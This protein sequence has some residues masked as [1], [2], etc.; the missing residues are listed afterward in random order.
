MAVEKNEGGGAGTEGDHLARAELEMKKAREMG[1]E[2]EHIACREGDDNDG[3]GTDGSFVMVMNGGDSD[4]RSDSSEKDLE[5]DVRGG[6]GGAGDLL[7]ADSGST[8]VDGGSAEESKGD[9]GVERQGNEREEERKLGD[10]FSAENEGKD[11]HVV[12]GEDDAHDGEV[13]QKILSMPVELEE[14]IDESTKTDHAQKLEEHEEEMVVVDAKKDQV[15]EGFVAV[16]DS[17]EEKNAVI[18]ELNNKDEVV[19][20]EVFKTEKSDQVGEELLMVEDSKNEKDIIIEG[21][22]VVDEAIDPIVVEDLKNKEQNQVEEEVVIVEDSKNEMEAVIEYLNKLD[23]VI[24][25]TEE[26][27]SEGTEVSYAKNEVDS[28]N[29][30]LTVGASSAQSSSSGF[31]DRNIK[32]ELL[33]G[34][35]DAVES[36]VTKLMN[37]EAESVPEIEELKEGSEQKTGDVESSI[38]EK[39]EADSASEIE[40]RRDANNEVAVEINSSELAKEEISSVHEIEDSKD[41]NH[42]ECEDVDSLLTDAANEG[43]DSNSEVDESRNT[44]DEG[45]KDVESSKEKISSVFDIEDRR[46]DNREECEDVESSVRDAATKG[47]DSNLEV[48]ERKNT[49]IEV[50]KDVESEIAD[51]MDN[52]VYSASEVIDRKI[53]NDDLSNCID[54]ENEKNSVTQVDENLQVKATLAVSD[55]ESGEL[56]TS[57]ELLKQHNVNASLPK[58]EIEEK[59][60][61]S[62]VELIDE[63]VMK[64]SR[65]APIVEEYQAAE[66]SSIGQSTEPVKEFISS[67][68]QAEVEYDATLSTSSAPEAEEDKNAK[69]LFIASNPEHKEDVSLA[70][71]VE[72]KQD[73]DASF[74]DSN[75]EPIRL[76][77]S[78]S[79]VGEL[80]DADAP[81][82]DSIPE[83]VKEDVGL[84]SKSEENQNAEAL[85]TE[86][87]NEKREL[88]SATELVEVVSK[89]VKAKE[90]MEDRRKDLN[91]AEQSVES[92]RIEIV[93]E[94][95]DLKSDT[96]LTEHKKIHLEKSLGEIEEQQMELKS[97]EKMDALNN[98]QQQG[99]E[100]SSAPDGDLEK[101]EMAAKKYR[102]IK[103]PRFTQRVINDEHQAKITDAHAQ[104]DEH[105]RRRDSLK[106]ELDN[107]RKVLSDCFHKRDSTN[108]EEKKAKALVNAKRLEMDSIQTVISKGK[109]AASF[110]DIISRIHTLEYKMQH[111]TIS[112]KDEKKYLHELNQLKNERELH[113]FNKC[114]QLEIDDALKQKET[115]ESSFKILKK[116]FDTLRN[117]HLKADEYLKSVSKSYIDQ[118]NK[119]KEHEQ[120][121]KTAND[122]RQNAY[123]NLHG[124]KSDKME[125]YWKYMDDRQVA[126]KYAS[127]KDKEA[128]E[129]HC[130]EQ[131]ERIMRLW[132]E[133][134]DF[135][136][137]YVESN[138]NNTL[139][140][141][142][143][144]DG[145]TPGPNDPKLVIPQQNFP[146]LTT[147]SSPATVSVHHEQSLHSHKVTKPA[148]PTN[149]MVRSKLPSE[150]TSND[151]ADIVAPLREEFVELEVEKKLTIEEEEQAR[152]AEEQARKAEELAR[153]EEELRKV[154]EE[155]EF[156]EKLRMEQKAKAKDAEE[157]KRRKA[158]KAQAKAE[159]KAQKQTELRELRLKKEKKKEGTSE[160]D[161]IV[162]GDRA[163]VTETSSQEAS[164]EQEN[165]NT[166]SS[167]RSRRKSSAAL[168]KYSNKVQPVPLPLRNRGKRKMSAWIWTFCVAVALIGLFFA[169]NYI[170]FSFSW[171]KFGF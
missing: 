95:R 154:R 6:G 35:S 66:V 23:E 158:E 51:H 81:S 133:D 4:A 9:N 71:M 10:S 18:E 14:F 151:V 27:V 157:R 76:L 22:Y 145:R 93:H 34:I 44:N 168:N 90:G 30:G 150:S 24:M 160:K 113:P 91:A 57:V 101:A 53:A 114:S 31:V 136:K 5:M 28:D 69:M 85:V 137:Q 118:F 50:I 73:L 32:L 38:T 171:L 17:K 97:E 63:L 124:L 83:P 102:L 116:E 138:L 152:L 68:S 19:D 26:Q 82:I 128:L 8:F 7:V 65:S 109:T 122:F 144:L 64:D 33:I 47:V 100:A 134:D 126:K 163:S 77:A 40:E 48:E 15:E 115:A 79:E 12:G 107:M 105:T 132:N 88:K 155:L 41:E 94:T 103:I 111:E 142:G 59:E 92:S 131:V 29:E 110:L 162:E 161:G 141:F 3:S 119:V 108:E 148:L 125:H 52:E 120:K 169:G 45:I 130:T 129:R 99:N 139:R 43:V 46:D 60:N 127:S 37:N 149:L 140:K 74:I 75:T 143:T 87:E 49:N 54:W 36:A 96:E 70:P 159:Y 104:V 146:P 16:E 165:N 112:L 61:D 11:D 55:G 42:E 153:K 164:Q 156:K 98:Q 147:R 86:G 39:K 78:T 106:A 21:L 67:T 167:K 123:K 89:P 72:E 13:A 117:A 84:A 62:S 2:I 135:R 170:S 25:G 166:T 20:I 56:V 80:Q 1:G 58:F 121:W